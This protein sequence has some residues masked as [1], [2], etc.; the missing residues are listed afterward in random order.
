MVKH[1]WFPTISM[2][3]S[4]K[5]V[6]IDFEKSVAS[7]SSSGRV[8]LLFDKFFSGYTIV[9]QTYYPFDEH[10]CVLAL[11]TEANDPH[12]TAALLL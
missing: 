10:M 8:Q 7:I 6:E 2:T 11:L 9:K 1:L 3:S 4:V 12:G 5:E